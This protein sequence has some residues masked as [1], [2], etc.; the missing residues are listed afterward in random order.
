[1]QKAFTMMELIFVIVVIGILSA[2]ALPRLGGTVNRAHISKGESTL[3]AVRSAL[4]TER[5][6]R[7]LRGNFDDIESL[8]NGFGTY[9]DENA[10][11]G[12]ILENAV[13]SGCTEVGCWNSTDGVTHTFYYQGGSC[14]FV[15]TANKLTGTC[16]VFGN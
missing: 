2:V 1:M 16:G 14:D 11:T 12:S 10:V 3:A 7:I 13:K 5:Q 8:S 6:K 9:T 4:S 15:L